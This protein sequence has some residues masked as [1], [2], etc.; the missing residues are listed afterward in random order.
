MVDTMM[1]MINIK[2]TT[3]KMARV[4]IMTKTIIKDTGVPEG[5]MGLRKTQRPSAT[6][7]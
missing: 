2:T 4:A 7:Q 1:A 5:V 6:S 3:T